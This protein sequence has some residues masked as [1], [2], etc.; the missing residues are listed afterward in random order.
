VLV[1]VS[2]FL[3]DESFNSLLKLRVAYSLQASKHITSHCNEKILRL[4]EMKRQRIKGMRNGWIAAIPMTIKP[5]TPIDLGCAGSNCGQVS[6][7]STVRPSKELN[8]LYR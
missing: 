3:S 1:A 4:R 5:L 7:L 2:R 8:F 6:L